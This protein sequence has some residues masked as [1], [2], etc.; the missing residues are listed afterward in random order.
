MSMFSAL[1][2]GDAGEAEGGGVSVEDLGE[3]LGDDSR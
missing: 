3:G 2:R 1:G